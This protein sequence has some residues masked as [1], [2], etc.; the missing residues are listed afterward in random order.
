ME[1]LSKDQILFLF[2]NKHHSPLLDWLM[3]LASNSIVWLP[4]Y[5]VGIIILLRLMKSMNPGYFISNFSL[6]IFSIAAIVLI[7]QQ[8]M[9]MIFPHFINRIKPCYD[10]DLSPLIHTVGDVCGD[11][12]G[13]YA[14]RAGTVVALSTFLCFSFHESFR[15]LKGLFIMWAIIVSYSRIYVGAHYPVN[16]LISALIGFTIGYLAYKTYFYI[17]ES[18]LVI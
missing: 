12:Y 2:F 5:L 8:W 10:D 9:P 13:F 1:A 17:K 4:L 16:V 15:W 14:F 6:V 11:K 18:L 7:C 3:N